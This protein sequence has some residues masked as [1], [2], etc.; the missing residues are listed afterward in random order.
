MDRV[1][2]IASEK[3]QTGAR[4]WRKKGMAQHKAKA[5]ERNCANQENKAG[6]NYVHEEEARVVQL[7]VLFTSCRLRTQKDDCLS[8]FRWTL[9][10]DSRCCSNSLPLFARDTLEGDISKRN[11]N[12]M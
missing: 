7:N 12:S 6:T 8:H 1:A 9:K 5:L 11:G 10:S 4:T 2:K 3:K